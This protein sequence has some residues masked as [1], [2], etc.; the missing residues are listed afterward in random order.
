LSDQKT[1]NGHP[2]TFLYR[3]HLNMNEMSSNQEEYNQLFQQNQNNNV[4]SF[5]N[6]EIE[7]RQDPL[8][9]PNHD[10]IMGTH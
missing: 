6:D 3:A 10:G 8:R 1:P 5:Y 7:E 9:I 2:N 4:S